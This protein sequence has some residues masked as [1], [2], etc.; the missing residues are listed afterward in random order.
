MRGI[1][2]P[3]ELTLYSRKINEYEILPMDKELE[4]AWRYRMGNAEAGQAIIN[5][6]LRVALK[7]S[8]AY[9]HYEQNPEDIINAGNMGL[10]KALEMFDPD[11]GV[12][13]SRHAVW[14]VHKH[15]WN[16]V[17]KNSR[18]TSGHGDGASPS[19]P[20]RFT[21]IMKRSVSWITFLMVTKTRVMSIHPLRGR[22]LA[23]L[24]SM[25]HLTLVKSAPRK[26]SSWRNVTR[27]TA[28]A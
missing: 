1:H 27:S 4:L 5:A 3:Y 8:R 12:R 6:N 20:R 9:F 23:S 24:P 2:Q 16:F 18:G 22:T 28:R 13:F 25:G 11:K 14:W 17:H 10:V 7:I 21:S 26:G 15:I 19:L